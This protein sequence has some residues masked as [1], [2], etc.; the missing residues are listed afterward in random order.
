MI[1]IKQVCGI[2]SLLGIWKAVCNLL[3]AGLS[4]NW[5]DVGTSTGQRDPCLA[6]STLRLLSMGVVRRDIR[7]QILQLHLGTQRNADSRG[8]KK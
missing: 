3:T 5:R 2:S 8:N 4:E 7:K 6:E 1:L